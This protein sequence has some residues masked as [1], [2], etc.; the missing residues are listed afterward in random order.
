MLEKLP[1]AVGRALRSTRP[2]LGQLVFNDASLGAVTETIRMSSSAFG[3]GSRL[4]TMYTADGEKLS[5]PLAW[6]GVPEH[7][8]SLVLLVEDA[9][10]PTPHPLVHAIVW[11]LPPRDG[12]LPEGALSADSELAGKG[13][14]SLMQR[15][16][17][18]PDPPRAHGVHHY[19]FELLACDCALEFDSAPGRT[20][21]LEALNGHVIAKG[22]LVGTY[23]R[24]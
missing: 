11:D 9:D 13:L 22:C 14:N 7:A 23:E 6:E 18:P 4:P 8:A 12:E 10:S 3:D 17:L 15:S 20:R 16:Y 2:G 5:P 19:A 24:V 1:T 21:L